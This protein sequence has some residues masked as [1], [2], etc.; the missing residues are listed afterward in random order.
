M[1]LASRLADRAIE[2]PLRLLP[3]LHPTAPTWRVTIAERARI[4]IAWPSTYQWA[5]AC[6]FTETIRAALSRKGV[7]VIAD[8]PQPHPGVV[9]L[10]CTVDGRSHVVAIDFADRP[11]LLS[12]AALRECSLYIKLQYGERG[13]AD[14]RIIPGGYPP[15]HLEYYRYLRAYRR[16]PAIRS[17]IDVAARFSYEFQ[18]ELR[19]RAVERL[20]S[21]S[22]IHFVG[23]SARV[24]YSRFLR[25][26]SSA[27]LALD[28]P[29]NGPFTFR[30]PEILG[31]G[32][33][34]MAPVYATA[35]HEPLVPGI[36]YAPIAHDLSDLL[37]VCRYY[38]AHEHE[39]TE[40]ARAGRDYFD[41]YLHADHLAGYYLRTLLDVVGNDG[42]TVESANESTFDENLRISV[43]DL[44]RCHRRPEAPVRL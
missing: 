18:R 35:L 19:S 33:C 12:E 7:L 11:D 44:D 38:L 15:S 13:Y 22:D 10:W 28:L 27:S 17:R 21:A 34:L 3:P 25:E 1:R 32:T 37:D 9:T 16:S 6:T 31:L 29:G 4:R 24:R 40:I 43:A 5:H 20:S 2:L 39:R 8:V 26:A 23:G 36:H 30:M 14:S 42:E 41:K